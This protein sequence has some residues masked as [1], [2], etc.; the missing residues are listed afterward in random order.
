VGALLDGALTWTP[1]ASAHDAHKG[2][3]PDS[4]NT[5]GCRYGHVADGVSFL[6]L[7]R[8]QFSRVTKRAA[9]HSGR[10][11]QRATSGT[12]GSQSAATG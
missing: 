2:R 8:T 5:G 10:F 1:L 7:T 3:D 12:N 4:N 9:G 6:A 11:W